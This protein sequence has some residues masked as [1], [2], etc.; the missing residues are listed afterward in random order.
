VPM[1][2]G[3]PVSKNAACAPAASTAASGTIT[4]ATNITNGGKG[5]KT[6]PNRAANK[7]PRLSGRGSRRSIRV[8]D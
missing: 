5:M 2:L 4:S 1:R 6:W 7:K 3:T 8:A